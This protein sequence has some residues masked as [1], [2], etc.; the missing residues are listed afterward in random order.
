MGMTVLYFFGS[1]MATV[2]DLS[3]K[4]HS[5]VTVCCARPLKVDYAL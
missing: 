2:S 3:V 1:R 4:R 5:Q